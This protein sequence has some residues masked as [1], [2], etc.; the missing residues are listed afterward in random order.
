MKSLV[1]PKLGIFQTLA[2]VVP[3]SFPSFPQKK[4]V[5]KYS[6][7]DQLLLLRILPVVLCS[8]PPRPPGSSR[9][10]LQSSWMEFQTLDSKHIWLELLEKWASNGLRLP[11]LHQDTNSPRSCRNSQA[12]S[13]PCPPQTN[14]AEHEGLYLHVFK[15][16]KVHWYHWYIVLSCVR[17]VLVTS[18]D[19]I[20][21]LTPYLVHQLINYIEIWWN[22][23]GFTNLIGIATLQSASTWSRNKKARR[24]SVLWE[25]LM[26][27][28]NQ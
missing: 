15:R 26:K 13:L 28:D 1:W 20:K 21:V 9:Y 27:S 8:Y 23:S 5:A 25:S 6:D 22:L 18:S 17:A 16:S 3:P 2:S 7:R 14:Q 24:C 11:R 10:R 12:Q 4:K 19:Y